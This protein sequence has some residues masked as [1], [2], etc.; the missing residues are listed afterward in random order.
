M[1][2]QERKIELVK[3]LT[4]A[5]L[6]CFQMDVTKARHADYP[7]AQKAAEFVDTV[8]RKCYDLVEEYDK[9]E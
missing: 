7:Y 1:L 8:F 5:T 4:V 6:G 2:S 9:G 3:E